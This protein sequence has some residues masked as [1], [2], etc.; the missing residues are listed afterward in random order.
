MGKTILLLVCSCNN[1]TRF[2]CYVLDD[3]PTEDVRA[4]SRVSYVYLCA[5]SL[6]CRLP[7]FPFSPHYKR[8]FNPI[9]YTE[10]TALVPILVNEIF[11]VDAVSRCAHG[12]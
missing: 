2:D 1:T 6:S 3:Q 7:S 5:A 10:G 4:R 11:V 12:D 8:S 9:V